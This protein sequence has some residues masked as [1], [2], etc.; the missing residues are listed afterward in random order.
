VRPLARFLLAASLLASFAPA[1]RALDLT[2]GWLLADLGDELRCR[3]V[4]VGKKP[5][6]VLVTLIDNNGASVADTTFAGCDGA[7]PLAPGGFCSAVAAGSVSAYC[8]VTTSSKQV[9]AVLTIAPD[10]GGTP[11]LAIP[12]TK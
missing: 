2:S 3:V 11:T 10:S 7:T 4:N 6:T 5:A 1:A 12:V 8:R 9:R